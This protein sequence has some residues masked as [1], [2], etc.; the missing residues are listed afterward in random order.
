MLVRG[1]DTLATIAM[2][3]L[4]TGWSVDF[5]AAIFGLAVVT[6]VACTS[7]GYVLLHTKVLFELLLGHCSDKLAVFIYLFLLV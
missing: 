6:I 3:A 1:C 2:K 5:V 4:P 7:G